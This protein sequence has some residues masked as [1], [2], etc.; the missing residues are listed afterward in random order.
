MTETFVKN[1]CS[2]IRDTYAC[3]I[4]EGLTRRCLPKM[5]SFLLPP[6]KRDCLCVRLSARG[7]R[8]LYCRKK[9]I[10]EINPKA[11]PPSYGWEGQ[12]NVV[13]TAMA[14]FAN[15]QT[16]WRRDANLLL[17]GKSERENR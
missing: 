14:V 17:R 15:P 9:Q 7:P 1:V 4:G 3:Y 6:V 11:S 10:K 13:H 16:R 2:T 5:S 12:G 8:S